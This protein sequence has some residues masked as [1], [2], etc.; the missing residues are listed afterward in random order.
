MGIA[1]GWLHCLMIPKQSS[2][3]WAAAGCMAVAL[4]SVGASAQLREYLRADWDPI[5]YQLAG[6]QEVQT[7]WIGST[8]TQ[9]PDGACDEVRTSLVDPSA[10]DASKEQAEAP[11]TKTERL[12][13]PVPPGTSRQPRPGV[14]AHQASPFFPM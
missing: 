4:A 8:Y 13:C 11:A 2:N 5:T 7:L 6:T 1:A 12:V 10:F 3:K 14:S 9:R